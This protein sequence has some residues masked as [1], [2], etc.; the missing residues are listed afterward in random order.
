MESDD[1]CGCCFN[2]TFMTAKRTYQIQIMTHAQTRVLQNMG[3][4]QPR[5]VSLSN[6]RSALNRK[7]SVKN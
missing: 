5:A 1:S 2:H 6:Q 4:P 3:V 7:F